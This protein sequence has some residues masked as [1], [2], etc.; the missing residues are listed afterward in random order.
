VVVIEVEFLVDGAIMEVDDGT[1]DVVE[2]G[3]RLNL[4]I[5][6]KKVMTSFQILPSMDNVMW[7]LFWCV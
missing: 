1:V 7:L 6:L 4:N 5:L 3:L 2:E